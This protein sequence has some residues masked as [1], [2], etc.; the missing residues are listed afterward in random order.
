MGP[1]AVGAMFPMILGAAVAGKLESY[2]PSLLLLPGS[3]AV[4]SDTAGGSSKL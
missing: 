3:L 4:H 2:A 1:A